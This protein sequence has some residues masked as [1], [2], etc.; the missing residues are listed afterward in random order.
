MIRWLGQVLAMIAKELKQLS[1]DP[2]LM[3]VIVYFFSADVYLAGSGIRLD[4]RHAPVLFQDRDHSEAS[5]ELVHRFRPPLFVPRGEPADDAAAIAALDHGRAAVVIDI[6]EDFARDILAG[7]R[8]EVLVQVDGAN[9]T[10]GT[11]ASSYARRIATGFGE[12]IVRERMGILH[13]RI[14]DLPMVLDRH[15]ALYNPNQNNAWF[16]SISE[17]LTVITLLAL[18]LPAAVTVREKEHG[19][20]EQ[21]AVAPIGVFQ[22]L[23]AKVL[24]MALVLLAGTWVSLHLVVQPFFGVPLRGSALLFFA[25]TALY[26]FATS[27]LSLLIASISRNLGQVVMLVILIM[28]PLI[29]LSGAWTPP[30]AMPS[31]LQVLVHVSPLYYF[32]ELGYGILLKGA[33]LEVL[34]DSMLGLAVVGTVCFGFGLWRF[35]H[36]Y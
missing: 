30:E 19:T 22:V 17:L 36:Q 6:P 24:A 2:V 32:I 18:M 26:V 29:L 35:R 23:M 16:M 5:R 12:E 27:G 8:A 25:A 4:L 14:E 3:L 28:M 33:G 15:R 20:V 7:R 11:L 13:D 1:R 9:A 31:L 10:L 21:L 34:W